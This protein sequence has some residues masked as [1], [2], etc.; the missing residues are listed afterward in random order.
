MLGRHY[1]SGAA[2]VYCNLSSNGLS[3][4]SKRTYIRPRLPSQSHHCRALLPF[5]APRMVLQIPSSHSPSSPS[6]GMA[7]RNTH[8][9]PSRR[10]RNQSPEG[11]TPS[12]PAHQNDHD[13]SYD[14]HDHEDGHSHSIFSTHSHSR[15]DRQGAETIVQA[16]QG[17][18][19]DRG[20]QITIIGLVVNVGLTAS[21]G[22]AGW[23]MNSAALLAE[24]GHSASGA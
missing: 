23:F 12:Q 15:D 21:K 11:S 13:H 22:A 2:R 17:Q 9:T 8:S 18:R 7:F 24:A 4:L 16:F 5:L 19:R 6:V 1:S 10:N 3:A 20:S 14:D